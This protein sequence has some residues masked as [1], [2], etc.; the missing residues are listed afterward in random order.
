MKY[1]LLFLLINCYTVYS[2]ENSKFD[3]NY[4]DAVDIIDGENVFK[5]GIM[6]TEIIFYP[7][8][9]DVIMVKM[10]NQNPLI[11]EVL[12]VEG[13]GVEEYVKYDQRFYL[14][15]IKNNSPATIT[16]TNRSGFSIELKHNES[17][18]RIWFSNYTPLED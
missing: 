4:Y 16:L 7:D 2:Q 12:S 9:Y 8:G 5:E 14:K 13:E 15:L 3:F 10:E 6:D 17:G 18:L 11:F 1:L